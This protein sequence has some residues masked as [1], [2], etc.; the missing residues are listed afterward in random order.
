MRRSSYYIDNN[1][2]AIQLRSVAH[3]RQKSA[4]GMTGVSVM[5]MMN[6]DDCLSAAVLLL[7][8]LLRDLFTIEES[9]Q[10]N[11]KSV[12]PCPGN[13]FPEKQGSYRAVF[14]SFH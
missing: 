11:Q 3:Q 1:R 10:S 7:A 2:I 4:C 8:F 13:I 12:S 5:K 9:D 6:P 14:S